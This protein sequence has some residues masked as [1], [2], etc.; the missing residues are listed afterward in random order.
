MNTL[1]VHSIIVVNHTNSQRTSF[2]KQKY[3]TQ[4]TCTLINPSQTV[5]GKNFAKPLA[6]GFGK[7]RIGLFLHCRNWQLL[8][9]LKAVVLEITVPIT[10][11]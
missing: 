7:L 11:L 9:M 1:N 4:I 6:K 2:I 10:S 5:L 3:L 8:E